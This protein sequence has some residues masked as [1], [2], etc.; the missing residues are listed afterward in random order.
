[1]NI[2]LPEY[3]MQGMKI[4]HAYIQKI[5]FYFDNFVFISKSI[6]DNEI[7]LNLV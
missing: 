6:K 1:M 3:I 4:I 2:H 7:F 5:N